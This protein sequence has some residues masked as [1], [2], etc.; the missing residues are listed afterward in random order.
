MSSDTDSEMVNIISVRLKS[1]RLLRKEICGDFGKKPEPSRK[2]RQIKMKSI[3]I[4]I[5]MVK[6]LT[7][8]NYNPP[9]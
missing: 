4:G 3:S 6:N 9:P 5:S 7:K 2:W 1:K 8:G